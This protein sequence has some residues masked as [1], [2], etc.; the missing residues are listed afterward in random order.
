MKLFRQP[1]FVLLIIT[2]L[3][4][5]RP[6]PLKVNVSDVKSD[7][8]VVRFDK[9][10]FTINSADT[11]NSIIA[12]SNKYPEFFDLFTYKVIQIGGMGDSLFLDGMKKF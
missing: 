12:I 9:E 10:L 8:E 3:F 11:L 2:L 7:I 6:N 1:V 4:S 5:C